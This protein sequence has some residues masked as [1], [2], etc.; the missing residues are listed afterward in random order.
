MITNL[1]LT[2]PAILFPGISLLLLA[3]TNR[4]LALANIVR[5]LSI[6]TEDCE[7]KNRYQQI[8][9]LKIRIE[10][11]KYMQA[12]GVISFIFCVITMLF[13]HI[14]LEAVAPYLFLISLISMLVSLS[15]ALLEILQSGK[16]LDLELERTQITRF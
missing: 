6:L 9:N 16:T 12:H 13:L 14:S 8:Q 4:N 1:E 2:D 5:T 15:F 3:Y 10:L 11:I 7:D